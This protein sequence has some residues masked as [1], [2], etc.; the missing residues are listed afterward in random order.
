ME[1]RTQNA[2]PI[3]TAIGVDIGKDVFHNRAAC[4]R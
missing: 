2:A 4:E 1:A 3:L